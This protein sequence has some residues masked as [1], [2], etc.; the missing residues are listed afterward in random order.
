V[1]A[2]FGSL[3]ALGNSIIQAQTFTNHRLLT[4]VNGPVTAD[5]VRIIIERV[6]NNKGTIIGGKYL[7]NTGYIAAGF[8]VQ[9]TA[10]GQAQL[11]NGL[12][13]PQHFTISQVGYSQALIPIIPF[14]H[15]DEQYLNLADSGN[16]NFVVTS[17]L[18]QDKSPAQIGS[19][20]FLSISG[21]KLGKSLRYLASP[22]VEAEL[23]QRAL[24]YET[25][26]PL[27]REYSNG[28]EQLNSLKARGLLYVLVHGALE[29]IGGAFIADPGKLPAL[30]AQEKRELEAEIESVGGSRKPERLAYRRAL[31]QS[32]TY[33]A[34]LESW[35]MK[36]AP[37]SYI[38][39]SVEEYKGEL[40]IVANLHI[41]KQDYDNIYHPEGA[42]TATYLAIAAPYLKITNTGTIAHAGN[43]TINADAL[44]NAK[45]VTERDEQHSDH[46]LTGEH[47]P[48][49]YHVKVVDEQTGVITGDTVNI[50]LSGSNPS[51]STFFNK[52]GIIMAMNGLYILATDGNITNSAQEV[53]FVRYWDP[54]VYTS[55]IGK[56]TH[57]LLG[58]Y[59]QGLLVAAQ[60][61]LEITAKAGYF[62]NRAS[63]IAA[64]LVI[65][66][67]ITKKQRRYKAP[68]LHQLLKLRVDVICSGM[69]DQKLKMSR[70]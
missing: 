2:N 34:T 40:C 12:N 19:C 35:R 43:I 8:S 11:V 69:A 10:K 22:E 50:T 16:P 9:L 13:T 41:G 33:I 15:N 20:A 37:Y 18:A 60:G 46:K 49:T 38:F 48:V 3:T 57:A 55:F 6:F 28:L 61:N 25:G 30:T 23:I 70:P 65:R 5:T 29:G 54:Y 44:V 36:S 51:Q 45:I 1:L 17:P 59:Q 4:A 66:I 31:V 42:I 58:D 53:T 7:R 56:D 62:N 27:L 32:G 14:K 47:N 64:V 67:S 68:Y 26:S 21:A 52:A 63:V 39:Y 24:Y